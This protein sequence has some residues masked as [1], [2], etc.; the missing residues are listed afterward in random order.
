MK[1]K[2]EL[3]TMSHSPILVDTKTNKEY[4]EQMMCIPEYFKIWASEK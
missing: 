2:T 1:N 4:E 3:L